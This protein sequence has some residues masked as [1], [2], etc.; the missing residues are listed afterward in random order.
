MTDIDISQVKSMLRSLQINQAETSNIDCKE[1]LNIKNDGDCASFIRHTVALANTGRKS[2]L[3]LGVENRSWIPT[4]IP[5]DSSLNNV[6]GT[7]QQ[8]NQVL[9]N[10]V[11]PPITVTYR[12]RPIDKAIIGIVEIE[13]KIPPYIIS[14]DHPRYGGK[15][16]KGDD[17]YIYKGAIYIRRATDSI[18][19]TRQSE[20]LEV[21][22]G[23]KDFVEIVV[24]L[25]LI[26]IVVGIGVGVG[27]S[28]IRFGDPYAST[29]LGCMWGVLVGLILNGRLANGFGRFQNNLLGK[30]MKHTVGSVWGGSVG[31]YMGYVMVDSILSGKTKSVNPLMG[32]FT[33]FLIGLTCAVFISAVIFYIIIPSSPIREVIGFVRQKILRR[34]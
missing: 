18:I 7:Q 30:L 22:N 23:R 31:A 8:M 29:V 27:T 4:G 12:I 20:V 28:T 6:D 3:L 34:H 19:A 26:G 33:G 11:D 32:L 9:S 21:L 10:R 25:A 13:G 17:S 5:G 1:D 15:K 16:T 2:Y 14:I 24:A